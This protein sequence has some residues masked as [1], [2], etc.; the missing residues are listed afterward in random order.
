MAFI[1]F[2]CPDRLAAK[3]HVAAATRGGVSRYLRSLAEA[4]L[5]L[6]PFAPAAARGRSTK[7]SLRLG[8]REVQ[9]LDELAAETGLLRTQYVVALIRRRLQRRPTFDRRSADALLEIRRELRRLGENFRDLAA[10][11]GGEGV[12]PLELNQLR[13]ELRARVESVREA[14]AGNLSYWDEST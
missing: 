10:R 1:G 12:T 8:E 14:L 3:V 2:R 7:L 4:D 6:E 9:Q 11:G 5:G 13:T